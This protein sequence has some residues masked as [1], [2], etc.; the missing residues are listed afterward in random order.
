[1]DGGN[2]VLVFKVKEFKFKGN[3]DDVLLVVEMGVGR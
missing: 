2:S 1:M 3:E